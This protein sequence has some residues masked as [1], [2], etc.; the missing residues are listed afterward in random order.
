MEFLLRSLCSFSSLAAC[1]T[2][3]R[4][5]SAGACGWAGSGGRGHF[6]SYVVTLASKLATTKLRSSTTVLSAFFS[7]CDLSPDRLSLMVSI[8]V[9]RSSLVVLLLAQG[10]L[11]QS[12][13]YHF[14]L[15][16][17]KA[18]CSAVISKHSMHDHNR[19]S[20]HCMSLSSSPYILLHS[21]HGASSLISPGCL[22]EPVPSLLFSL[23]RLA[24][25]RPP[26]T[27]PLPTIMR[28]EKKC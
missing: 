18:Y 28:R 8:I 9:I 27:L 21:W 6:S 13:Q 11:M 7:I 1:A 3:S 20:S 2:T 15:S 19:Q 17:M 26:L 4:C 10:W 14:T 5:T 25:V 22:P 23:P 12:E 16:I 24:P